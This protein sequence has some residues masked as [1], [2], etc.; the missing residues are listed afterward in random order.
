[1]SMVDS[2]GSDTKFQKR[3]LLLALAFADAH[4]DEFD[5]TFLDSLN[6]FMEERGYLTDKQYSALL[7]ILEKWEIEDW[8]A[9][10][11]LDEYGR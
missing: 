2:I 4:E 7:N 10:E 5:R 6:T 9:R 8:A 11:G 1:M 3:D